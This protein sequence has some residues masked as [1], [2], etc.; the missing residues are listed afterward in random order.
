MYVKKIITDYPEIAKEWHYTKN[1][2]F[3]INE[4]RISSKQKVWWQ[5]S[6]N[7]EHIW[8]STI[9]SR[10][11]QDCTNH[12]PFCLDKN[13]RFNQ[14]CLQGLKFGKLTIEK[15]V[16]PKTLSNNKKRKNWL[17]LCDCGKKIEVIEHALLTG[18]TRSC[19]C[20]LA[21]T[22][23][24]LK[25]TDLTGRRFGRLIVENFVEKK[26]GNNLWKCICN[27]KNIINVRASNLYSGNTQ[28][29]GC[30]KQEKITKH[31]L[32]NSE[33]YISYLRSD[34][35]R[36]IK[37]RVSCYVRMCIKNT[38][39][40]KNI[41]IWKVLPYT[42]QQLRDYLESLWEPWMN[43][44]N[45]GGRMNNKKLTWHIDHIIPQSNFQFNSLNDPQFLACWA[46]LNLRPLEKIANVKKGN[47]LI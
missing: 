42:P 15:I 38:N 21:E 5:C 27:C 9:C 35:T 22:L 19:G 46:L 29:C 23:K 6:S 10:T 18:N 36:R 44:E 14:R 8:E 1:T 39:I 26:N 20:S 32:S 4:V 7:K 11:R 45:Y 34:P 41:S 31:G 13:K 43:W 17:C 24:K 40:V 25:F 2:N 30:L 37:H 12:C 33:N 16:K 3:N 28:S 47:K